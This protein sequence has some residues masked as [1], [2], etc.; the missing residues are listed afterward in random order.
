VY[1][2]DQDL[3]SGHQCGTM[4]ELRLSMVLKVKYSIHIRIMEILSTRFLFELFLT[5]HF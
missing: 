1:F 2:A 4:L 3:N 5:V